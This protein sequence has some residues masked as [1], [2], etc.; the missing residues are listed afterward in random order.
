[1]PLKNIPSGIPSGVYAITDADI[2]SDGLLIQIEHALTAGVR[3]L[4]YRRKTQASLPEAQ[5]VLARCQHYDVPLIIN[6]DINLAAALGCGVH[7]GQ[8]DGHLAD[9]RQAL[10]TQ[11]IIGYSC[12]ASLDKAKEAQAQGADYLAF[13]A[14]FQS[15]TKPQAPLASLN[16]ITQAKQQLTTPIV[17]IGGINVDNVSA[18]I[19]AGADYAAMIQGL[20]RHPDG[21]I[22]SAQHLTDTVTHIH[23]LYQ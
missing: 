12:Y 8:E 20:W 19:D 13:G 23:H 3:L 22:R 9:A 2:D 5:A 18:V 4:Q 17:A 6:D 1:M 14:I 7:L 15:S 11:A 16:I 10:G 21:T